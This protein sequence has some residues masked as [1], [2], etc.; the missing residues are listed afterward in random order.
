MLAEPVTTLRI[1]GSNGYGEGAFEFEED[2]NV[3]KVLESIRDYLSEHEH[4]TE[5]L[6]AEVVTLVQSI[7]YH[8][9]ERSFP[10]NGNG[11]S[12]DWDQAQSIAQQITEYGDR[13]GICGASARVGYET[14]KDATLY[15]LGS[16]YVLDEV[17]A[18]VEESGS[19]G[20]REWLGQLVEHERK[21]LNDIIVET[22]SAF[23]D[24]LQG[25]GP[26]WLE[27][28][29]AQ[30]TIQKLLSQPTKVLDQPEPSYTGH[31]LYNGSPM[32]ERFYPHPQEDL[33]RESELSV[34]EV[35]AA[36]TELQQTLHSDQQQ[37]PG[38]KPNR[39]ERIIKEIQDSGSTTITLAQLEE[40]FANTKNP[41]AT[42][43]SYIS[44]LK[45]TIEENGTPVGIETEVVYQFRP[46]PR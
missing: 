44:W 45:R 5:A 11:H 35:I 38:R 8:L 40:R 33:Q 4:T 16:G 10:V 19:A 46:T 20:L 14:A 32:R 37:S 7:A 31:E 28:W 2:T 43:S 15:A 21:E 36:L 41:R 23:W 42:A 34:E 39:V 22:A 25:R 26:L 1:S 18:A 17:E 13:H 3:V 29:M 9:Q 24:K 6:P 27:N 12:K 30:K